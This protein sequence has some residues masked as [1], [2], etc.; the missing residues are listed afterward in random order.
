[1]SIIRWMT[2]LLLLAAGLPAH[3]LVADQLI[4]DDLVVQGNGCVGTDCASGT[5]FSNAVLKMME[6]NL[7]VRFLDITAQ[8]SADYSW[9]LVGNDSTSGGNGY[10]RLDWL[11]NQQLPVLSDGTAPDYDCNVWPSRIIGTI[12]AGEPTETQYCQPVLAYESHP[13]VT[14]GADG[15]LVLGRDSVASEGDLSLGREGVVRRLRYL[16]EALQETDALVKHQL[17]SYDP[18]ASRREA[19][20]ALSLR[21]DELESGIAELRA[22]LRPPVVADSDDDRWLGPVAG[23]W[24][25]LLLLCGLWRRSARS[26]GGSFSR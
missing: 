21:A 3:A 22:A 8:D 7:R 13:V 20:A 4:D 17:D 26:S 11:S 24:L 1:M 23:Y 25:S 2:A 14:A 10:I 5:D 6:N 9:T 18:L 19:L 15:S 12:P 16:A